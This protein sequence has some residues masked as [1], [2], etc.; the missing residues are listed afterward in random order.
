M[1]SMFNEKGVLHFNYK[2]EDLAPTEAAARKQ[3][4]KELAEFVAMPAE[5]RTFDNTIL[6]YYRIF[7]KYH[8]ALGVSGFLGYVSTDKKLRDAVVELEM[9]TSQYLV[10]VA[11]RRDIYRAIRQY[12]DTNPQL[13][14]VQAKLVKEMLIGFKYKGMDLNDEDLEKYKALN[15]KESQNAIS[16]DQN[17]RE[18][19][20]PLY[21]TREQL[22]GLDEDYIQKLQKT[23]DGKYI[24]TLDSLILKV[25][26]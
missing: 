1:P 13:D 9:Q 2:A 4:E 7:Q 17:I 20:D 23:D 18:Y 25:V 24:V 11:A 15:K 14:P 16:F 10:D 21:V 5:K 6:G 19:K 12:T 22:N 26:G 8:D 3:L